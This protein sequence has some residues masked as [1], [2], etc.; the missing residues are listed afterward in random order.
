MRMGQ[1]SITN[2][3]LT[4]LTV[5]LAVVLRLQSSAAHETKSI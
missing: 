1:A 3:D 2:F 5:S 4:V